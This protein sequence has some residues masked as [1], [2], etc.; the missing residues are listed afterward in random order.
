MGRAF[1]DASPAGQDRYRSLG[2]AFYRGSDAVVLVYSS[3]ESLQSLKSWF[4]EFRARCP[5]E[6]GELR[7]FA[8]VAVGNKTDLWE[9]TGDGVSPEESKEALEQLLPPAGAVEIDSVLGYS[10]DDSSTSSAQPNPPPDPSSPLPHCESNPSHAAEPSASSRIDVLPPLRPAFNPNSNR[11]PRSK[12]TA[13][14]I[15]TTNTAGTSTVSVYHDAQSTFDHPNGGSTESLASDDTI[16]P[17]DTPQSYDEEEEDDNSGSAVFGWSAPAQQVFL[18][19]ERDKEAARGV[20]AFMASS[21]PHTPSSLKVHE[22]ARYRGGPSALRGRSSGS[23]ADKPLPVAR[24]TSEERA[25]EQLEEEA[26]RRDVYD[27]SR[28]GIKEFR[29]SAKTG[30]GVDEV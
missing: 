6:E 7:D 26:R 28:D 9:E 2:S 11:F 19:A 21:P 8:W 3:P 14:S 4:D 13:T 20:D 18:S 24:E 30:E 22:K 27:Y 16:T 25:I 29:T 5:V 15:G 17:A 12:R 10:V 1:A 23:K